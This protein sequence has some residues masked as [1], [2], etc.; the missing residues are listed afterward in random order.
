[1]ARAGSTRPD[2]LLS[3]VDSLES[4]HARVLGVVV[5][6]HSAAMRLEVA[7]PPTRLSAAGAA[8]QTSSQNL[9]LR[10]PPH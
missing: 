6:G 7:Q 5:N 10:G 1:V 3:A 8:S 9:R 2:Q 4:V